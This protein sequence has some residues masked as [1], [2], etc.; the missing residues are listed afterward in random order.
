MRFTELYA[1]T[2]KEAPSDADLVSIKLLIRA[3]F[4]RKVAA[5]VYTYL[6]LGYKVLRKVEKIVREEM[7]NIGCQEFLMPIIQPAELWHESGRW[8]DYGPEMMKLKDRHERDFTLG[9]THEEMIT[10]VVR[11]E[12]RS[13]RQLPVSLYQ[14]A[15]KY[16]DEIR[17]RFG[18]IRSREFL[19]K[20]AYSFHGNWE[21]INEFYK[22]FY[23]AYAR[24]M[25]R[26]GL[27]YLIV[28]ADS[29]AIGGNESHEFCSLARNGEEGILYCDCGYSATQE[30]ADYG[31][32]IS[33]PEGDQKPIESV[34]TPGVRTVEE[35][36]DFV[37]TEAF[38]IVKSLVFR[39]K[40]GFVMVLIRGD[41]ELNEAKLKAH[42][43]DQ[44]LVMAKPEEVLEN[45]EVPIG[46]IGPV[47]PKKGV[48]IVADYTVK[49]ME[50][51]IVGGMKEGY[52]YVNVCYG[53]DFEIDEW[54]NVKLAV[55]GDLCPNCGKSMKGTRGID[56]G[57][58]FKLGTKYSEAMD[59]SHMDE[60]S[61]N[62][63]YIMGCYGW[64]ISR[65]VSA[66]VEQMHD[67][68]GIL[69]PLSIAPFSVI[70]TMVNV[71]D[72]NTRRVGEE[73]YESLEATGMDVLI[74]DREL[75]A[76]SKFKDADLLGVP[77]RVTVGKK[78]ADSIVEI[79]TRTMGRDYVE[80][81]VRDGYGKLKEEIDRLL[82]DYNP[83]DILEVE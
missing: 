33:N 64:G 19:M 40:K 34:E 17:P 10:S 78:I 23:G 24:I 67:E 12:L 25:D 7:D 32:I 16:R 21:S 59:G 26:I 9:P 61:D 70:V 11:N 79:K 44:T 43:G 74:D 20:D 73:I 66:V 76:G 13:Y 51:F 3:G 56:L 77:L 5:G 30:R 52:H 81:S 15:S 29:G 31:F 57:Q 49:D 48:T 83:Q 35:V 65:T 42:L 63:P 69:W 18:L 41:Q 82:R 80:I 55:E 22:K 1:P 14:I 72:K 75:S 46:F 71:T 36:A 54:I 37:N 27:E 6:P 4:V 60:N 68:N 38:N 58:V 45:F 8:D 47:G 62:K 53:R 50:N 28:E 2:L 39:G